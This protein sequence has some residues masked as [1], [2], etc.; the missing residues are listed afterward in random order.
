MFDGLD[1]IRTGTRGAG[2]RKVQQALTTLGYGLPK[3]GADGRW[4]YEVRDA[5]VALQSANEIDASGIVDQATV[6]LLDRLLQAKSASGTDL[7]GGD[8][9]ISTADLRAAEKIMGRYALTR[10]LGQDPARIEF[11]AIDYLQGT[12]GSMDGQVDRLQKVLVE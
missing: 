9:S 8:G 5:L 2:L 4:H 12:I 1:L 10:A 7:S 11:D 6:K 3:N